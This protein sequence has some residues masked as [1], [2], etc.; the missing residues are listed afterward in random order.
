MGRLWRFGIKLTKWL[1]ALVLLAAVG[2]WLWVRQDYADAAS[3]LPE[4][5]RRAIEFGIPLEPA[6][7][8]PDP[9][10]SAKD[11]AGPL[12]VEANK[13]LS[14]VELPKDSRAIELWARDS[15]GRHDTELAG[16]LQAMSTALEL[17]KEASAR[18]RCNFGYD[19]SLGPNVMFPEFAW[20]KELAKKLTAR[21]VYVA[22]KGQVDAALSDLNAV[23]RMAMH[24]GEER[25]LIGGLVAVSIDSIATAGRS[26][27]AT[28]WAKDSAALAKLRKSFVGLP[29]KP[30][31]KRMFQG[32][33]FWGY[34]TARHL[35][36]F[37]PKPDSGD[38]WEGGDIDPFHERWLLPPTFNREMVCKAY[39]ARILEFWCGV[40]EDNRQTAWNPLKVGDSTDRAQ[41]RYDFGRTY[42]PSD[43]LSR[44]LL[45]VFAQAG[46]AMVKMDA[47]RDVTSALTD[48]LVFRAKHGRLPK[49]LEEAGV[50][51]IDPFASDWLKYKVDGDTC[52]V[53]S[54]GQDG[55]DGGG[56]RYKDKLDRRRGYLGQD[57]VAYF[58][59]PDGYASYKEPDPP[60]M[61]RGTATLPPV[62]E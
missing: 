57:T 30:S 33:A 58:P 7:M 12:Y 34:Y 46:R 45:P 40:F 18:P 6:G 59:A 56:L 42:R 10:I 19:Y 50:H 51:A 9:P 23:S 2:G 54:V 20:A 4:L 44:I 16:Y 8:R 1:F 17:A 26:E 55:I 31:I 36:R 43:V 61:P 41:I 49:T 52:R 62:D 39:A 29:E 35:E 28:Y 27:C 32:E 14:A 47:Y 21:A 24:I 5:E 3:E 11:N 22:R 60:P 37:V 13:A 38:E 15:E 48:V 25:V 53:Y